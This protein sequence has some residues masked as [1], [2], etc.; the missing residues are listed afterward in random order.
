MKEE[1]KTAMSKINISVEGLARVATFL[2][3]YVQ[4]KGDF[5]PLGTE[6]L[7]NLWNTVG[8][9]KG[10]VRYECQEMKPKNIPTIDE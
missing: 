10:D 9:L 3:G 4:G 1:Q 6:D 7:K 8:F 5:L 2:S